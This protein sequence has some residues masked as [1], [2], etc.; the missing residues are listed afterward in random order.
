MSAFVLDC[1]ITVAW[2]FDDEATPETDALLD[3]L[4]DGSALVPGLWH[5]EIANVLA[6]AERHKR[7]SGA[8]VAAHVNLLGRLPIVTDAETQSRAFR[9]I[10]AL[11]GT[12]RLST[13]DAAYLELA[14]RRGVALAT[15]DKALVQAARQVDVESLPADSSHRNSAF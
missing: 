8:Q 15:L 6:C 3:R 9:E 13:Y 10:L 12:Q 14:M 4:K 2:L 11:A 1:S 7:I 5:L